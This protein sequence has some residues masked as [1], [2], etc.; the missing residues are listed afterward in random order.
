M[1]IFDDPLL[2]EK[3]FLDTTNIISERLI[4]SSDEEEVDLISLK[5]FNRY[6]LPRTDEWLGGSICFLMNN[7]SMNTLAT[8]TSKL[9]R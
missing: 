6:F 7:F 9:I 5:K 3:L 1:T 2:D 8:K 4:S